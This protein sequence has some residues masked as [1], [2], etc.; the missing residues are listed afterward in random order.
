MLI[1][2]HSV[3]SRHPLN[4]KPL[5]NSILATQSQADA[6]N[7]LMGDLSRFSDD[8]ILAILN[9]ISNKTDILALAH[10]SR[11]MYAYTYDE[12]LW[13]RLYFQLAATEKPEQNFKW[14]GSWRNSVLGIDNP[15]NVQLPGAM[16]CSDL[17][18]RPYQC[19]QV[20]YKRVFARIIDDEKQRHDQILDQAE[21]RKWLADIDSISSSISSFSSIVRLPELQSEHF[22][23]EKLQNKPFILVGEPGRWPE[24]D[25]DDLLSRFPDVIF[26]QEAAQWPFLLYASYLRENRDESPLYLFDCHS[27]AMQS[28][29]QEYTVPKLFQ[30]DLFSVFEKQD[31]RPDHAWLIVG[32]LRSGSTF[33]K[34]PNYTSAW[35]AA[36]SGR[37]LWVMLPPEVVP[38]GVGTDDDESEVTS[39]VGIAE[40]VLAGFYNDAVQLDECIVAVTFPGECMHVP[41]GWWHS[42]INIDDSVALTQNFAPPSKVGATLDF[43]RRRTNQVS[44]FTIKRVYDAV[45]GFLHRWD[46]TGIDLHG[47]EGDTAADVAALRNFCST[48]ATMDI[49]V[50]A[51]EDCGE[52]AD[53]PDM[54]I[55]EFFRL[56][57][58]ADGKG[59]LLHLKKKLQRAAAGK[60]WTQVVDMQA[61]FSFGF[62][63]D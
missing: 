10:T 63:L 45:T 40:W 50:I 60:P 37:K 47:Y 6:R 13:R 56:L 31:C 26:R 34:D 22:S 19:S 25:V 1:S 54:P 24:W 38:P 57:L 28:L 17:L 48:V 21:Q 39:P 59:S 5:G 14:L 16:V 43:F 58:V 36:L 2:A 44:G 3:A 35:N 51:N 8:I 52:L 53:M 20:D 15:A 41:A 49:D 11:V 23:Y 4:V 33:H 12:E 61:G 7:E 46:T 32:P 55:Y 62:S 9:H 30:E 29:R 42:V 18:Y 27:T